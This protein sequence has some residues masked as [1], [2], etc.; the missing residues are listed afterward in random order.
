MEGGEGYQKGFRELK[1]ERSERREGKWQHVR[2]GVS[3]NSLR[4]PFPILALTRR[5]DDDERG[6]KRGKKAVKEQE[7]EKEI[8]HGFRKG[9]VYD[10]RVLSRSSLWEKKIKR[11]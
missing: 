5:R 2:K 3:F 10:V 11:F 8:K 6:G 1:R 7:S 9:D 4:S